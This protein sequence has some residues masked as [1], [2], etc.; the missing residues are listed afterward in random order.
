MHS[1]IDVTAPDWQQGEMG[2]LK[3]AKHMTDHTSSIYA[4]GIQKTPHHQ[5]PELARTCQDVPEQPRQPRQPRPA[6]QPSR[7]QEGSVFSTRPAC[8]VPVRAT[9]PRRKE[10]LAISVRRELQSQLL[11]TQ[12]TTYVV[13]LHGKSKNKKGKKEHNVQPVVPHA[14]RRVLAFALDGFPAVRLTSPAGDPY[15]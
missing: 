10:T 15:I 3:I 14:M 12:H 8:K 9:S 13:Y 5:L 11:E 6:R 4:R 7:A 1:N 2:R